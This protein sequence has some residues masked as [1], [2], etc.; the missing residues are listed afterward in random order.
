MIVEKVSVDK[1]KAKLDSLGKRPT[2]GNGEIVDVKQRLK[3]IEERLDR[4]E[5]EALKKGHSKRK[6][7]TH[8]TDGEDERKEIES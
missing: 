2:I 6:K 8:D 7:V 3:E 5:M 4:E 1:V